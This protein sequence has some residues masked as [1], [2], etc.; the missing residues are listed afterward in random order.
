MPHAKLWH[1]HGMVR[2]GAECLPSETDE[3][4]QVAS[5]RSSWHLRESSG[6]TPKV[7]LLAFIFGASCELAVTLNV[8]LSSKRLLSYEVGLSVMLHMVS[9]TCCL[10]LNFMLSEQ[11]F[12]RGIF[13]TFKS[14]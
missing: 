8:S 5:K 10:H 14:S 6:Y 3:I 2:L 12:G 13:R 9:A 4:M 11:I 1:S 7:T